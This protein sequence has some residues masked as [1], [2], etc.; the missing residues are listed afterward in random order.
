MTEHKLNSHTAALL[1]LRAQV[2]QAR[3]T[4]KKE[5]GVTVSDL[6]IVL[7]DLQAF[8]AAMES[9]QFTDQFKDRVAAG[10]QSVPDIDPNDPDSILGAFGAML[11]RAVAKNM[12]D[13]ARGTLQRFGQRTFKVKNPEER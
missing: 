1:R 11:G 4:R 13:A 7:D 6:A 10:P 12:T 2:L 5:I 3:R 8:Y 9:D